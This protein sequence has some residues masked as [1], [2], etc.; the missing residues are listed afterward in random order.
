MLTLDHPADR[1]QHRG[2][3]RPWIQCRSRLMLRFPFG[4]FFAVRFRSNVPSFFNRV[5]TC[6][7][8]FRL[9]AF[10]VWDSQVRPFRVWNVFSHRPNFL[11]MLYL[12]LLFDCKDVVTDA[13]GIRRRVQDFLWRIGENLDPMIDITS[14]AGW[15]VTD[16]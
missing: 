7:E 15:I 3:F 6:P 11:G 12:L 5:P 2:E 8:R 4:D 14:V 9:M 13:F 1:A 10:G 16:P